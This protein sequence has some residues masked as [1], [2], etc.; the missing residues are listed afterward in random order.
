MATPSISRGREPQLEKCQLCGASGMA[1]AWSVIASAQYPAAFAA[2][3][4]SFTV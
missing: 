1:G 2:A 4:I 3:A